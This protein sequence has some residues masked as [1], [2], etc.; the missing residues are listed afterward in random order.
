MINEIIFVNNFYIKEKIILKIIKYVNI[1]NNK[2][3]IYY[4]FWDI[5][6]LVFIGI[7]VFIKY[8]LER[9]IEN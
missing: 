9:N 3:V 6:K 1:Y 2:N 5:V 8:V 7:F 4:N